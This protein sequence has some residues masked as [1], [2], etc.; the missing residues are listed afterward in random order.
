[1]YADQKNSFRMS[2][3][4]WLVAFILLIVS[5]YCLKAQTRVSGQVMD[6]SQQSISFANILLLYS[7][8]STLAEGTISNAKGE[9]LIE[10]QTD[11]YILYI[12]SVGYHSVSSR[13]TVTPTTEQYLGTF[14]LIESTQ[15]L[16]EVLVRGQKQLFEK[17]VDRTVVNVQSSITSAGRTVLEVLEK[18]PGVIVNRQNNSIALNGK[19]GVMVMI[20]GKIS[21]LPTDAV[22]QMLNGMSAANIEKIE[23]ITTPPAKYD[24]EG[25]AGIIH[26]VMT[27]NEDIGTNGNIGATV[28]YSGAETWGLN[29]NIN[30]RNQQ[31]NTFFTYS[32]LSDRTVHRWN[33]ERF[34]TD[35]DFIEVNR[36]FN[37]RNPITTVQNLRLGL[38]YDINDQ[39]S[40]DLLI[41]GYRRYWDTHDNINNTNMIRTDSTVV[42]TVAVH[43]INRWNSATASIGIRHQLDER[44]T[45]NLSVDYLYYHQINP[46][47]YDNSITYIESTQSE[48]EFLQSEK[49]TPIHFKI[50]SLDYENTIS[51]TLSV[52][53]GGKGSLSRFTNIVSVTRTLKGTTIIDPQFTGTST[54][55]EKIVAAYGSAKWQPATNWDMQGGMRYEYTNTHL[56]TEEEA[57]LVDREFGNLFPSLTISYQM[58]EDSKLG[59]AYSRRITRPTYNDLAPFVFFVN[60]TTALSG[61]L[62]LRPAISDGFDLSYQRKQWWVALK[63]SYTQNE[64]VPFQPELDVATNMQIQRSQ[65][66]KYLQSFGIHSTL[67]I[68]IV[69]WWEFRNDASL[70]LYQL[71]TQHLVENVRDDILTFTYNGTNSFQLPRDYSL[72]IT[73]YYQSASPMGLLRLAP[74]GRL[75][76]GLKKQLKGD[77]G[78]LSLVGT[79]LFNTNFW[80][81]STDA[82]ESNIQT[83]I[84]YNWGLR[85]VTL[86]YSRTLGNKKLKKVNIKSGSDTERQRVQ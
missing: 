12:T 20:N 36:S 29:A 41:T 31:V 8:D 18:S 44:Q 10:T 13:L 46:S 73:G 4:R 49:S 84:V 66:L 15:E 78:M 67:P 24:A 56:G 50:G 61:N 9:F 52:E 16:D 25:N 55:D 38:E 76:V 37:R 86:S 1:M 6:E 58:Q 43:G 65:N 53:A 3:I 63:Y 32:I 77:R 68:T 59:L 42:N 70:Y 82:P 72:E 85:G 57:N 60:P 17:Q 79:D 62:S 2:R 22:V 39:T 45:I 11:D 40:V 75:D 26:L 47:D 30:H 27:E 5:S 69:R 48:N 19:N 21:R 81:L 34:I 14:Q 64:I 71:Q 83:S 51:P 7:S 54:L 35:G 74:M 28:G 33:T 80:R 23:L